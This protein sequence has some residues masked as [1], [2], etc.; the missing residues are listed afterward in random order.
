MG[1]LSVQKRERAVKL[2]NIITTAMGRQGDKHK[3]KLLMEDHLPE[4][5]ATPVAEQIQHEKK[6]SILSC[7]N[8]FL[9]LLTV[10]ASVIV[11]A[12]IVKT[13]ELEKISVDQ[14]VNIGRMKAEAENTNQQL[15]NLLSESI[16]KAKIDETLI[17]SLNSETEGMNAK[18]ETMKSQIINKDETNTEYPKT[19]VNLQKVIEKREVELTT[20][21]DNLKKG[22]ES[23]QEEKK[24]ISEQLEASKQD[25]VS[26][27]Q[28]YE[29]DMRNVIT[30]NEEE[31]AKLN[32][33]I[34]DKDGEMLTKANSIESLEDT[35]VIKS[36]SVA[37]LEEENRKL[38]TDMTEFT[39][40]A[41]REIEKIEE[42]KTK[43]MQDFETSRK[44][45]LEER[46]TLGENIKGKEEDMKS[47][48]TQMDVKIKA[49][50]REYETKIEEFDNSNNQLRVKIDAENKEKSKVVEEKASL[51]DNLDD[52]Q[53]KLTKVTKDLQEAKL[54]QEICN[55]ENGIDS[56]KVKQLDNQI[57]DLTEKMSTTQEENRVIAEKLSK[58]ESEKVEGSKQLQDLE[59]KFDGLSQEKTKLESEYKDISAKL[60][61]L[62]KEKVKESL[63]SK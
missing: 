38:S 1:T 57:L 10:I 61:K 29:I 5:K 37:T 12:V 8:I 59:T 54:E 11:T 23:F 3:K 28:K 24:T 41:N 55:K 52:A 47:L 36:E 45:L 26:L 42:E 46:I 50:T 62:E 56:L 35:L 40:E 30:E 18:I 27:Q 39:E 22:F 4:E 13:V 15:Q 6:D 58:V 44:T 2:H 51:S 21:S 48:Q 60:S 34:S 49:L 33:L 25:H 32:Q 19:Q 14:A 7:S 20:L 17:K 63:K 31:T 9:M 16:E 43:C 53:L